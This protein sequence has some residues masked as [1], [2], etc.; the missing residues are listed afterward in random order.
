MDTQIQQQ[1]ATRRRFPLLSEIGVS[2]SIATAAV[3]GLL[4]YISKVQ[5]SVIPPN[6]STYYFFRAAFRINDL[7]RLNSV[8]P[9]STNA[10]A[11]Q[12]P[13][14]SSQVGEELL[15]ILTHVGVAALVVLFLR[16]FSQISIYRALIGPQ[17]FFT[18]LFALPV[19][20]SNLVART[21]PFASAF[22]ETGAGRLL[23]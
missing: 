17:A 2:V 12:F 4:V 3:Y 14:R 1:R 7:L 8:E 5:L 20:Y 21:I 9:V 6:D 11:R 22:P 18:S 16:L 19:C 23:H 15:A 10:V 13:S